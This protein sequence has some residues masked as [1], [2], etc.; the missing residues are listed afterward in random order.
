MPIPVS[1]IV[2]KR[3]P[4]YLQRLEVHGKDCERLLSS[5]KREFPPLA[6][7]ILKVRILLQ[8]LHNYFCFITKHM[9]FDEPQL[10]NPS[11]N[12]CSPA[13]RHPDL[14]TDEHRRALDIIAEVQKCLPESILSLPQ[15]VV[16]GDQSSGKSSI[17]E[18][19]TG[20]P[21]PRNDNL[22]TRFA[23]EISFRRS[24]TNKL[25]IRVIP[26]DSRPHSEKETIKGFFEFIADFTNLPRIMDLAM[27]TM[28]I[29]TSVGT[30]PSVQPRAFARDTL[31]I[32]IEGP[33]R[34]QLT[35]VDIPG[36]IHTSTKGISDADVALVAEITDRYISQPRTICLAVV[37]ASNDAE[38]QTILTKVQEVDPEGNRT[39]G[40]ITKPDIPPAGSGSQSAFIE[41]ARNKDVFF[42]LGWHVLKNRKFEESTHS[43][44]ERNLAEMR[45]FRESNFNCLP[46]EHVG[47]D[48]LRTRLSVLL[49][50][51]V[52]HEFPRFGRDLRFA[53]RDAQDE[54]NRLGA[55][56]S[57][58]VECRAYLSRLSMGYYELCKAA[59]NGNY[60]GSF[61]HFGSNEEFSWNSKGSIARL[62]AM[63]QDLNAE[64]TRDLQQ[65]G[66]KFD[67]KSLEDDEV[68]PVTSDPDP[69]PIP[70]SRKNALEWA[71]KVLVRTRGKEL[72]GSLN[73]LLVAELFWEQ[74][75]GWKKLA[76]D[77]IGDVLLLCE[78]FLSLLLKEKAPKE[79]R[80][81]LWSSRISDALKDRKRAAFRELK[82]IMEDNRS[83][84]I[85]Y[86]RNYTVV[87]LRRRHERQ[88]KLLAQAVEAGIEHRVCSQ[89]KSSSDSS[90]TIN[91][92][93]VARI[94]E[95]FNC[96]EAL[97]CLLAIY[98]ELQTTFAANITTQV[99][100]R[101]V[102]RGLEDIFSPLVVNNMSD[103]E[104]KTIASEPLPTK[105]L[106]DFLEDRIKKLKDGLNTFRAMMVE[107]FE[108]TDTFL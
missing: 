81:R 61:F 24:T 103:V 99:I 102:V 83:A 10:R 44:A 72:V 89:C 97:D 50:E 16:C 78:K 47:I 62:R 3:R 74:S 66:H 11:P 70:L 41:L 79:V 14:Q 9:L 86:N 4:M 75:S 39:L 43:L 108:E 96:E 68:E 53:L 92:D 71:R 95:T 55:A 80:T 69:N 1:G 58:P 19:L 42:K 46:K 21:F 101:H 82:L 67:I 100:E 98:D 91:I 65:W 93:E 6:T 40:I 33:S 60:E 48:T 5:T 106:R 37:S 77:H 105:N 104:V 56:R 36:L 87:V 52:K 84:P 31:S 85:N 64:F 23:T 7:G 76:S 94:S 38:N 17:L 88:K 18:A 51:H 45:F 54:R 59:V 57:T 34:P 26:D 22:C 90:D 13:F 25:T 30:D 49:F 107:D 32:E 20:I 15:L 2:K 8:T 35:L 27:A 73:P 63:V 12:F 28:G 29:A